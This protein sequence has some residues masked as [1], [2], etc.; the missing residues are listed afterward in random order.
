MSPIA[1][2]DE[3]KYSGWIAHINRQ[4]DQPQIQ[5]L[6][7]TKDDLPV[8]MVARGK[9][10]R[11][12]VEIRGLYRREGWKLFAQNAPVKAGRAPGEFVIQAYLNS[13]INEVSLSAQGPQGESEREVVYVYAPDAKELHIVS[14]WDSLLFSVGYANLGYGQTN[15]GYFSSRTGLVGASY[16]SP[17]TTSRFGLFSQALMTVLTL[18]SEPIDANPQVVE[19][20]LDGTIR[21]GLRDQS[22][23]RYSLI[24]GVSYL[25]LI[26]NGSPFGFANLVAPEVGFRAKHYRTSQTALHAEVRAVTLKD[27]TFEK[28]RGLHFAL[29]WTRTLPSLK[30]I[31]VSVR[32]SNSSFEST[33]Q[34]ILVELTSISLGYS[35]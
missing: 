12:L 2:A 14:A 11:P 28:Q 15:F 32:Y 29:G 26:S 34:N 7:F 30:L 35:M 16:T 27:V 1:L 33:R 10:L 8:L 22:R 19:G 31:D 23:W 13:Q 3:A 6:S 9:E 5:D 20:R 24:G 4:A 17:E 18:S 25:T 21:L